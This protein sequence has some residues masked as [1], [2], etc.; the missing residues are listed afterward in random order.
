MAVVVGVIIIG[1][2]K[3]IAKVTDKVVPFM[4]GIYVSR[5]TRCV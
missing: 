2:I 3:S 5:R 4:V 1:G